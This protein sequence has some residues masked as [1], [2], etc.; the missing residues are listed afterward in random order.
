MAKLPSYEGLTALVTGASSG[1]GRIL[2]RRLAEKGANLVLVARRKWLL[3][4]L[5][6]E[7]E[8]SGRQ[9]MVAPCDVSDRSGMRAVG[10]QALKRFGAVDLL[11]NNAGYGHHRPFLRWDLDDQERMMRVNFLGS[12]YL[13]HQLAPSMV[14]R[15]RG[16]IVFIASG[17]GRIGVPDESAYSASKFAMVGLAETL[18]M[19]LA[20]HGVHV[21][22]VYPGAVRTSF[23]DDEAWAR[24]APV[25][26]RLM[27]EP[28]PVV[29]AIL[30]ALEKG[31]QELTLPRTVALGY[32]ARAL[33]PRLQRY[34]TARVTLGALAKQ[35]RA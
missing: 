3:E 17:A 4:S 13:T 18:M 7:I 28:E 10:E 34:G 9:A 11:V 14:A 32:V 26:K 6:E 22:T 21:L 19:E 29:E 2:A 20:P 27:L 23:F 30:R 8:A 1:M 15:R 24:M 35:E 5:A 16:W 12:L 25:E 31:K 33:V